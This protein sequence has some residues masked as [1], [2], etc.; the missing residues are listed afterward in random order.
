MEDPFLSD[1]LEC[2]EDR[3]LSF[4]IHETPLVIGGRV[5]CRIGSVLR[6][7]DNGP[8]FMIPERA[9]GEGLPFFFCPGSQKIA[10]HWIQVPHN[11]P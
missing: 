6:A 1:L 4:L 10:V 3:K 8:E 11:E 7:V 2:Q 9:V 5:R